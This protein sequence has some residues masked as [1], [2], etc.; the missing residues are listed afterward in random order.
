MAQKNVAT[1]AKE[2]KKFSA[3]EV[4]CKLTALAYLLGAM[5]GADFSPDEFECNGI[6][7]LLKEIAREVDPGNEKAGDV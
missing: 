7:I 1:T 4:Y 5:K 2:G 3:F 6:E